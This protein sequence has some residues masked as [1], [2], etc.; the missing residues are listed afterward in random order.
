MSEP[1][2]PNPDDLPSSLHRALDDFEGAWRS[3]SRP[4]MEDFLTGLAEGARTTVLRELLMLDL[5]H[6]R[7]AGD[8]PRP[9]DYLGRFP[10]LD[11]AWLA[12]AIAAE[13][14]G[15]AATSSHAANGPGASATAS[16]GALIGDTQT[17]DGKPP[18][19]TP[20]G[21]SGRRIGVY[22][23]LEEV[24][25]GG[26]GVVYKAWQHGLER[27]V[28]L[29]MIRA[30]ALASPAE[31]RR[32]RDEAKKAAQ[33]QH[34][35]IVQIYEVG[36]HLGLPFFTMEF[37]EGGSLARK[38]AHTPQ[39]PL[40]AA[41]VV[42]HLARAMAYAHGKKIVHRDLKPANVLLAADG[43][44][45]VTDFGIAKRLDNNTGQTAAGVIMGTLP[46]MAPE[47]AREARQAGPAA[48][49]YSLGVILYEMLTGHP[50]FRGKTDVETLDQV[51]T[52]EPVPPCRLRPAVPRDLETICLKC[53]EKEPE[54]RYA[55]AEALAA[56]V[57]RFLEHK[58][59]LA[60]PVSRWERTVKWARRKPAQA[61]LLLMTALAVATA[62]AGTVFYGLYLEQQAQNRER[63]ASA[64][65]QRLM[66]RQA[67]DQDLHD[68]EKARDAGRS[69]L[70]LAQQEAAAGQDPQAHEEEAD[71][72]VADAKGSLD[73]AQARLGHEQVPAE[74]D[75]AE[76]MDK[77]GH[78]IQEIREEL[79]KWR[80]V[81]SK[82]K[83]FER[84][85]EE[86]L[87]HALSVSD[88]ERG[89]DRESILRLAPETLAVWK[90]D[91]KGPAPAKALEPYRNHLKARKR[92]D[93]V[94]TGCYEVILLW[95]EAASSPP[96]GPGCEDRAD[97]ALKL[98]E[99]AAD[100]GSEYKLA[101]PRT[102]YEQDT[103]YRKQRGDKQ[104]APRERPRVDDPLRQGPLDHFL[105]AVEAYRQGNY[106]QAADFSAKVLAQ[107]PEQPEHF[108]GY[109]LQGLCY[110]QTQSWGQA[111]E[112]LT[113][114]VDR[115]PAAFWPRLL[116]ASARLEMQDFGR[117][118]AD[119]D[120]ALTEAGKD[121]LKRCLVL[122][123]R[124]ILCVR[125]KRWDAAEGDL[126]QASTLQPKA[127]QPWVNLAEVYR[128]RAEL[129]GAVVVVWAAL[130]R[131]HWLNV[132][133]V[134][135]RRSELG[136]AVAALGE[137]LARR[138]RDPI[139]HYTRAQL[140]LARGDTAA[141]RA[142]L[143]KVIELPRSEPKLRASALV[144]RAHLKHL[145]QD[146]KSALQDVEAALKVRPQLGPAF[147]QMATT[148]SAMGKFE[149]AGKALDSYLAFEQAPPAEVYKARALIHEELK[150]YWQAL[151]AYNR[152]LKLALDA[153]TLSRRGWIY[154]KLH[155]AERALTDF[156]EALKRDKGNAYALAGRAHA[157]VQ[158]Q[159]NEALEDI[160]EALRRGP[161]TDR[162]LLSAACV[163]AQAAGRAGK[164]GDR[165]SRFVYEK[166]AVGLVKGALAQVPSR[167]R[168]EFWQKY[169]APE[170]L[171]DPVRSSLRAVE[172]L[173]LYGP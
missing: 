66:G 122:T 172:P 49:T 55:S 46:Y 69:A 129:D 20:A 160:E 140:H 169:V 5:Y 34:P 24:A 53:L 14:N 108:W 136:E 157:R 171:L 80:V 111:R 85:Y 73:R 155:G 146:Y 170:G 173:Q 93:R 133:E 58:P 65:L 4:Q 37:M 132:A 22:E 92:L 1:S 152:A 125:Q 106:K 62:A 63:E 148:L 71:K 36:E 51:R 8:Q 141:A 47:Q 135:R 144:S 119:F 16:H 78:H 57:R 101:T 165:L 15:T 121:P 109:Y 98:L 87:F 67:A 28:A 162:L 137:A 9:E 2:L 102:F 128:G 18:A 131:Q 117:A 60:R 94:V 31:V 75:L 107:E 7:C 105:A 42:E 97:Q 159:V 124:A 29:K 147:L 43:R 134:F 104:S 163:Y 116:R 38:L 27:M 150:E 79:K 83:E 35:D 12:K 84:G 76:K 123:S 19:A 70:A 112:S 115:R 30:G 68:A 45:K 95:A 89:A 6:R 99:A 127:Y 103:R 26:M 142:D 153:G 130:T 113:A 33:L 149:A 3:G 120:G 82:V 91:A 25:H 32:F 40:E 39:D 54:R 143:D 145:A 10:E 168:R 154:L 158:D 139:L 50:P 110:L 52:Q 72:Q 138:P 100:L 44:H 96:T 23:I 88:R 167:Q 56:D 81:G 156:D 41:G 74:D 48:D 151:D 86:V 61:A 164:K 21:T 11:P 59:I 17:L 13:A 118:Q 166:E 77:L 161:R 114:C 90:L 64:T 126:R